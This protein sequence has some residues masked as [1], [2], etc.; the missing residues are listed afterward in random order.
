[1]AV[2]FLIISYIA[3]LSLFI[4][5]IHSIMQQQFTNFKEFFQSIQILHAAMFMG[6]VMILII[7][8]FILGIEDRSEG[9]HLFTI[10]GISVVIFGLVSGHFIYNNRIEIIKKD[11]LPVMEQ[12]TQYREAF[13]M[14]LA[15][16]EAPALICLILH[17]LNGDSLLFYASVFMIIMLALARPTEEKVMRELGLRSEDVQ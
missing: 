15:L 11:K 6:V 9:D 3:F 12:L 14:N 7:L 13:I 10:L 5:L 2:F 1:M 8:K 4:S 16:L 17:F